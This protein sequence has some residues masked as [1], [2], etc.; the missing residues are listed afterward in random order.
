MKKMVTIFKIINGLPIFVGL[1]D[2]D[3]IKEF[4]KSYC[5]MVEKHHNQL[6]E[7][8]RIND[9]NIKLAQNKDK[10][11]YDMINI[12]YVITYM[13]GKAIEVSETLFCQELDYNVM[14][15]ENPMLISEL[16]ENIEM[17]KT[18]HYTQSLKD[19]KTEEDDD[20]QK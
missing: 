6:G 9:A 17:E 12:G 8:V 1:I 11:I 7:H 4:T 2:S 5:N 10:Y 18:I 14:P 20:E 3:K 15:E 19:L 16:P 13:E